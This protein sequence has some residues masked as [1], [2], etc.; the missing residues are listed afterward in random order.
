MDIHELQQTLQTL[1]IKEIRYSLNGDIK[2]DAYIL[3]SNYTKWEVYYLDE[4]YV[5]RD[6]KNFSTESDACE[7][8]LKKFQ[9]L[10]ETGKRFGIKAV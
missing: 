3:V 8:I 6:E 2:T 10:I 4:R 1:G 9:S 7:Y 5:K